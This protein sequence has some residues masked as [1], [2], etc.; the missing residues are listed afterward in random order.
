MRK[1]GAVSTRKTSPGVMYPTP[2]RLPFHHETCVGACSIEAMEV[3]LGCC[4]VRSGLSQASFTEGRDV[5]AVPPFGGSVGRV[6][7]SLSESQIAS[8]KF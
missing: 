7:F 8:F 6:C 3:L 4:S 1:S 2:P 5:S